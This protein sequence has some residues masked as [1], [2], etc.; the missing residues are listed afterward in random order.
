[1]KQ[2]RLVLVETGPGAHGYKICWDYWTNDYGWR[3][4]FYVGSDPGHNPEFIAV[5]SAVA[6]YCSLP[7]GFDGWEWENHVAAKAAFR[8]AKAALKNYRNGTGVWPEWAR[9]ALAN[10]WKAPEGWKPDGNVT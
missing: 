4:C 10:G 9:T 8:V 2:D 7:D 1:V 5:H 6:A 3:E